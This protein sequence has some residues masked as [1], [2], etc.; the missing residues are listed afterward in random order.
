MAES[1]GQASGFSKV[2][3]ALESLLDPTIDENKALDV[4]FYLTIFELFE[5]K[6]SVE[7]SQIG[8]LFRPDFKTYLINVKLRSLGGGYPSIEEQT[9]K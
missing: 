7:L 3:A 5:Y 6:Y 9:T 4:A 1:S 8:L 2:M